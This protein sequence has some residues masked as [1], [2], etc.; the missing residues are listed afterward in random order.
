MYIVEW[1]TSPEGGQGERTQQKTT[2]G[3]K[4]DVQLEIIKLVTGGHYVKRVLKE[5]PFQTNMSVSVELE[6]E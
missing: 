4:E 1:E 5:I 3:T 2:C 6:D